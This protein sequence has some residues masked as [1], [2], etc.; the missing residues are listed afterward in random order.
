MAS[1]ARS[2]TERAAAKSA[3]RPTTVRI[4]PPF[5][6]QP[7]AVA[8]VPAWKT[9]PPRRRASSIPVIGA[10]RLGPAG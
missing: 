8:A 2:A 6:V 4:R 10:S 1:A 9:S 7:P 5:V 3:P